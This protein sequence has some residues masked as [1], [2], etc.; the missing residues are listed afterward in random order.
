V[1][2]HYGNAAALSLDLVLVARLYARWRVGKF[3]AE[4]AARG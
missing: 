1:T 2:G 4:R 3:R